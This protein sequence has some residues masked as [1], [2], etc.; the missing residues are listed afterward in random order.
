LQDR[1]ELAL[2]SARRHSRP[3]SLAVLDLDCF[4]EINEAY[5]HRQGDLL[6]KQLAPRLR[7]LLRESDTVARLGGDEF[8]LVLPGTDVNGAITAATKALA[9]LAQPFVVE[10]RSVDIGASVGIALYPAHGED[11]EDLLRQA[12]VAMYM[13]KRTNSGYAIYAVEQDQF[14][15]DR[16]ALKS[17]MREAIENDEFFLE[18]QPKADMRTGKVDSIEALVRWQ[19]PEQ[20]LVPPDKFISLVEDAGLVQALNIHVLSAALRQSAAW[21]ETGLS[22]RVA[23]NLSTASLK[24][25]QVVGMI[26]GMLRATGVPAEQLEIDVP[27]SAI[28]VDPARAE[29]VLKRLHELGIRIAIDDFGT[30][31]ASL[32]QLKALPVDQIKLDR[33]LI[34]HIATNDDDAYVVRSLIDLGHKLGFSVV[35]K[36]VEDNETAAILTTLGCDFAQGAYLSKPVSGD[37]VARRFRGAEPRVSLVS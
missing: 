30:S 14:S 26:A 27:E 13:A 2:A 7:G 6:L 5:G 12:D 17:Q 4:R 11:A 35:A 23:V 36:G 21:E 10:G 20:G 8:A 24:D 9:S 34:R 31:H 22:L 28:T 15:P 3:V 1:L 32:A 25:E 18:Y 33:T 37:D 19:H 29:E 16:L